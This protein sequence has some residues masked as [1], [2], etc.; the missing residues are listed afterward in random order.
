MVL[1]YPACHVGTGISSECKERARCAIDLDRAQGALLGKLR[2]FEVCFTQMPFALLSAKL[3]SIAAEPFSM[4]QGISLWTEV[5]LFRWSTGVCGHARTWLWLR[6]DCVISAEI[7]AVRSCI[8]ATLARDSTLS[9][10]SGSV[11][12]LRK[13][14]RH[15]PKSALTPSV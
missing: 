13:L 11:L 6:H 8:K 2:L 7:S 10:N 14:K 4:V 12:E 3:Q 1:D 5:R 15:S 9:R